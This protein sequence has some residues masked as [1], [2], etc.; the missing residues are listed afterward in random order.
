MKLDPLGPEFNQLKNGLK[1]GDMEASADTIINLA[2]LSNRIPEVTSILTQFSTTLTNA[3]EAN[4]VMDIVR[5]I[6]K[7]Q[8]QGKP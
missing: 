3:T 4:E 1:P 5:E 8:K 7:R 6:E 2:E